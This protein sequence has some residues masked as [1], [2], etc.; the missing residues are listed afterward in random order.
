MRG[1]LLSPSDSAS[2]RAA[3]VGLVAVVVLVTATAGVLA[4]R[5]ERPLP[6]RA[7]QKKIASKPSPS[8]APAPPPVVPSAA[9]QAASSMDATVARHHISRL[10]MAALTGDTATRESALAGLKRQSG[11]ALTLI[12]QELAREADGPVRSAFEEARMRLK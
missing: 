6:A 7:P 4:I 2:Y 3:K 11:V 10:R 9:S 12:D 8:P 1:W 5:G